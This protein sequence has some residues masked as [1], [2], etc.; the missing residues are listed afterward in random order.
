MKNI[1]AKL[2]VRIGGAV[3]LLGYAV[4]AGAQTA[5][6]TSTAGTTISSM[7]TDVALIIG[8][9][10]GTILALYSAL[11]GLGWGVR[12]FRRYVSGKKF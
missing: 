4:T 1:I 6:S 9:V 7:I 12:K 3:T 10:V 8:G 11:V 2:S 5:F